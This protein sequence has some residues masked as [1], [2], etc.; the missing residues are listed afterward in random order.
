MSSFIVP[1]TT[2]E[3]L[4]PHPK[5]DCLELAHDHAL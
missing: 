5:A 3:A 2:I 1:V 4:K